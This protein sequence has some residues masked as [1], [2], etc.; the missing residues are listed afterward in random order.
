MRLMEGHRRVAAG[1]LVAT[2]LAAGGE[3]GAQSAKQEDPIPATPSQDLTAIQRTFSQPTPPPLTMFPELRERWKDTPAFLRDS[4]FDINFRSYYRD[5]VTNAP[6]SVGIREAWAAGGSVAAETGRLFDVVS[7]GAVLYTSFP[8]YAPPDRGDTGLLLPNQQGYAVFGQLYARARLFET[9]H[10]T[11]GRYLYDTPFLGPHDNRMTPNTFFGYT[12]TGQ[13]GSGE[14]GGP[15]F[16][17]GAGW[18][19]AIKPRDA[20]DFQSMSRKAGV[21]ADYG[22]GLLGGR[23]TWGPASIGA[24]DYYTEDTLNIVYTEGSYGHSFNFGLNVLG[25]AQFVDQRS[26]GHNLLNSGNYFATNQFG[27]KVDLGYQTGILTVGYSVVN[28]T[29]AIQ[30]PWS[31]NPFYTDAQIQSFN[32]AGEQAVMVG[33]SYVLTPIGL[34]GVAASVF[35]FNGSTGAPAA[36]APLVETEWDFNLEWR[37]NWKPLQGLWLRARYGTSSVYQSGSRT[38]IDEVRLILNYNVKLY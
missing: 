38:N 1:L 6:N 29:F 33:L 20:I 19:G 5:E 25:A 36:G 16:N 35:Y 12:L 27:A 26:A 34:P 11:A 14:N 7:L 13:F 28:P 30:T 18:I 2:L 24:I 21:N 37:P 17:Y 9:H 31:A 8:I 4:K 3:A 23:L 15:Q 22:T 10:A 32:R